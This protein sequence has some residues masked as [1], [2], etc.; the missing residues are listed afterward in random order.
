[1]C[2]RSMKAKHFYPERLPSGQWRIWLIDCEGVHRRPSRR[3]YERERL[4]FL[5]SLAEI[6]PALL[7]EFLRRKP[8]W[9]RPQ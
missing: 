7:R 8:V 4:Q 6:S 9:V 2:W 5:A 1:M 3:E